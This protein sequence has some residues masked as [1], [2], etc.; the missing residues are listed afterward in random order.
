MN[1]INFLVEVKNELAKVVW[2]TRKQTL[3]YTATVVLFSVVIAAI[4][5][6][7]DLGL[8]KIFETIVSK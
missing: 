8:F 4:L 6:A 1:P 2:P 5:G 7:A 3:Q